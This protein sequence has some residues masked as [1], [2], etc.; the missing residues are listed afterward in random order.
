MGFS[1]LLGQLLELS[2]LLKQLLLQA[3][4]WV[5]DDDEPRLFAWSLLAHLPADWRAGRGGRGVVA[6][7]VACCTSRA[8]RAR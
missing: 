1:L 7:P 5:D 6:T 4:H 2:L 3:Y 8:V